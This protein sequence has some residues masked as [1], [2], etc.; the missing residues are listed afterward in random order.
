MKEVLK[1]T[2]SLSTPGNF[3]KSTF[4]HYRLESLFPKNVLENVSTELLCFWKSEE[5]P[6]W[7]LPSWAQSQET[8]FKMVFHTY[9]WI[10]PTQ[11]Q[12]W[13][14]QSTSV[15][16]VSKC[17]CL[18]ACLSVCVLPWDNACL[19]V[20]MHANDSVRLFGIHN[21]F[22]LNVF[23]LDIWNRLTNEFMLF[24]KLN[25]VSTN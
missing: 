14:N 20:I 23:S 5:A 15:V 13:N 18:C 1:S 4:R 8:F 16:W 9:I 22:I 10:E 25:C 11:Y 12:H 17:A 24:F 19:R 21:Y 3:K 6:D 2:P 7:D